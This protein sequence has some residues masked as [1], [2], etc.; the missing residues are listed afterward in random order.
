MPEITAN[1]KVGLGIVAATAALITGLLGNVLA[2][3][4]SAFFSGTVPKTGR[5]PMFLW[6]AFFLAA[7]V[8]VVAGS[9]ATFAPAAA[10]APPA[11]THLA[12]DTP[13]IV[14]TNNNASMQ[15]ADIKDRFFICRDIVQVANTADVATSIV[16]VG[17]DLDVNGTLVQIQ[18]TDAAAK[19]KNAQF[20]VMVSAWKTPPA[21][22]SYANTQGLTQFA[23]IQGR[24][25]PIK[26]DARSTSALAVDYALKFTSALPQNITAT[27]TLRFPDIQDVQSQWMECK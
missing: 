1:V 3:N 24:P 4:I 6:V 26:V 5:R 12:Q 11:P 8:S 2:A 13:K 14:V 16:S 20:A 27:H 25:L 23:E 22:K 17:T 21:S 15:R 10:T 18:P 19:W 7:L 9:L